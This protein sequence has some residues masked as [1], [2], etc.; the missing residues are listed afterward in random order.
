MPT[1][2]ALKSMYL[3]QISPGDEWN[4]LR[5]L[6]EADMR[7]L[8]YSRFRWSR[9]RL[10]LT[11]VDGIIT[12]P[13]TH[14]SILGAQVDGYASEIWSEDYEFVPD[15]VGEV[16]VNGADGVRLIDQGID[17]NGL[18]IYKVAGHLPDGTTVKVLA[19]YAPAMLYDP[20]IAES[21]LPVDAIT[22]TRCP[23]SA[24]L[25]QIM[26]AILME[27]ASDMNLSRQYFA[28]A[29]KGL[30]DRERGERGGAKPSMN[31]RSVAPGIRRIRNLR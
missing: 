4:F 20:E 9:S 19:H 22:T 26:L 18:R 6:T 3:A 15:G 1:V 16:E 21:D 17:D 14:A 23:D 28:V 31:L 29:L 5:L 13:S 25:K 2:T 8:S 11:P 7:A 30:D 24:A 27:E 12:L 10:T